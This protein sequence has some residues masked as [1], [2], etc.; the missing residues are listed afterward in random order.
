MRNHHITI[1]SQFGTTMIEVLITLVILLVGL[2]GLAGM[3]LQGQ[4]S[5]LES[6]Q[7]VQ[8]LILMQDMVGRIN[9]NRKAAACYAKTASTGTP[10]FGTSSTITP[11]CTTGTGTQQARAIQDMNDWGALL[12]GT[13]ETSGSTSVGAMIGARGCV[14]YDT[15]TDS[16]AI[17][18]TWQGSAG[19]T[20]PSAAI[21]CATGQYGTE[22]QR[23]AVTTRIKIATL[24]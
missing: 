17:T 5:E 4:R 24:T 7:R 10:Y 23:R 11:S 6:Y 22:T 1:R 14:T 21:T 9:A 13:S 20:A 12:T 18:V 15:T 3:M 8:A 2:L 16:Y 19:V